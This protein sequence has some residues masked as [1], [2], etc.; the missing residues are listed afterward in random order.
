[1]V[2]TYNPQT[3]RNEYQK[4]IDVIIYENMDEVLYTLTIDDGN[5]LKVTKEHRLYVYKDNRYDLLAAKEI[6]IGDI[7]RYSDGTHHKVTK[8]SYV[9]IKQTVYNLTIDNNHNFY[10]GNSGILVHNVSVICGKGGVNHYD[11]PI[12]GICQ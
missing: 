6:K 8:T 2:L 7:V 4:I 5:I 11:G 1:M 10:V 9:P 3:G 12:Q